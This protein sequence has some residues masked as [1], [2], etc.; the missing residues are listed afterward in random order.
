MRKISLLLNL[1]CLFFCQCENEGTQ[2]QTALNDSEIQ[3]SASTGNGVAYTVHHY[4]NNPRTEPVIRTR[5][6]GNSFRRFIE[7]GENL[8]FSA[9]DHISVKIELV[10][11]SQWINKLHLSLPYTTSTACNY[12]DKKLIGIGRVNGSQDDV[13][14]SYFRDTTEIDRITLNSANAFRGALSIKDSLNYCTKDIRYHSQGR[15]VRFLLTAVTG[16]DIELDVFLD[17]SQS[18]LPGSAATPTDSDAKKE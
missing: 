16:D 18:G 5:A 2:S 14:V 4:S 9:S 3:L 7:D 6:S 8:V 13:T 17:D 11:G 10:E 12:Q 15:T 1:L